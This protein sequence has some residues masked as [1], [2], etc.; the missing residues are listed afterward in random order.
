MKIVRVPCRGLYFSGGMH[1][2]FAAS[3]SR[4]CH[5]VVAQ[6]CWRWPR[7]ERLLQHRQ[8]PPSPR[9]QAAG[10]VPC[11]PSP[12][13]PAPGRPSTIVDRRPHHL[14]VADLPQHRHRRHDVYAHDAVAC[15]RYISSL[16]ASGQWDEWSAWSAAQLFA[17][18][19]APVAAPAGVP[20]I[21][22]PLG[23]GQSITP[24]FCWTATDALFYD[25]WVNDVTTGTSQVIRQ[26]NVAGTSFVPTTALPY[27]DSFTSWVRGG[28]CLGW[29]AWSAA[30][31][32]A[33]DGAPVAPP[34]AA[35]SFLTPLGSGNAA[36][37]AFTWTAVT[38]CRLFRFLA[39]RP[40]N[41]DIPAHPA[42][43]ALIGTSFTPAT[44][45]PDN[46]SFQAWVRAGNV[47]GYGPWSAANTFATGSAP[48]AA[49]AVAPVLSAPRGS[50]N[51]ATVTVAWN[52]VAG[53]AFF[54]LWINDETSGVSQVVR[55]PDVTGLSCQAGPLAANDT[56]EAWVRAG[57]CFGFGPWS[58]ADLFATGNAPIA[59]PRQRPLSPRRAATTMFPARFFPGAA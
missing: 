31:N 46:H 24:T 17:T 6:C 43:S 54:D 38:G 40:D 45:L 42:D 2:G 30:A 13:R 35:P 11:R 22:A 29:S 20:R 50:G 39:E 9:R 21:T 51:P 56:F 23:A 14:H 36:T 28:N 5:G 34:T 16:G 53:A 32:F 33:T 52:N 25:L 1:N 48:V 15:Q 12:G 55:Q 47:F 59:P 4:S 27:S 8:R 49:P 7:L 37:V 10:T 41:R 26:T 44:P 58:A 19:N 57:N 18:G 3:V